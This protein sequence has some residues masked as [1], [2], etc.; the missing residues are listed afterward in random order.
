MSRLERATDFVSK[1]IIRN[2][3][4]LVIILFFL[5]FVITPTLFVLTYAFT[6][7]DLIQDEVIQDPEIMSQIW[8]AISNSCEI[9]VIVTIIDILLGLPMA[10]ILVRKKFRGKELIDTLID[11]PLAVPT[12]ALGFSAAIFW[13]ITPA[14]LT[15]P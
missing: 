3:W 10:W 15:N 2:L 7:W 14:D 1:P 5:A 13:G 6:N 9:A 4:P 8:T 12:A 11:M